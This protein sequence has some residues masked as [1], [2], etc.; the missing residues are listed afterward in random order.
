MLRYFNFKPSLKLRWCRAL[1]LF[2]S[3]IPMTK[4]GLNFESLKYEVEVS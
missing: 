2:L 3:Q 1:D 4:G